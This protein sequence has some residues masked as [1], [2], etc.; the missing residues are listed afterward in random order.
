MRMR[1]GERLGKRNPSHMG[2]EKIITQTMN[3]SRREGSSLYRGAIFLPPLNFV[4]E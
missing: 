2:H 4:L 3:Y 1:G